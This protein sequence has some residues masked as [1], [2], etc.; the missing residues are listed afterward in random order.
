MRDR[1]MIYLFK[2]KV[3]TLPLILHFTTDSIMKYWLTGK[4]ALRG[5]I[6]IKERGEIIASMS[7]YMFNHRKRT[8]CSV[9]H[10]LSTIDASNIRIHL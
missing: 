8:C 1:K 10:S 9:Y 3:I 4:G 5:G 2:A 7:T 6:E